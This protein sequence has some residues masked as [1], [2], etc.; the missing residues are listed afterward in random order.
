[1]MILRSVNHDEHWTR[2]RPYLWMRI[3]IMQEKNLYLHSV[4][5]NITISC[6]KNIL[7]ENKWPS[8]I[9]QYCSTF[10]TRRGQPEAC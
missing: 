2:L 8:V 10:N 3:A 9:L 5:T 4:F 7:P 6:N 1:M